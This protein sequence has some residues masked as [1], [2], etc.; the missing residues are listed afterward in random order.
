MRLVITLLWQQTEAPY[1]HKHL[2]SVCILPF[3]NKMLPEEQH[4]IL[5]NFRAQIFEKFNVQ[6]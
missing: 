1:T 3:T 2:Q 6:G 4:R 5:R